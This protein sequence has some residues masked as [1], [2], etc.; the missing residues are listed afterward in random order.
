MSLTHPYVSSAQVINVLFLIVGSAFSA[1]TTKAQFCWS[2][3]GS[4]NGCVPTF[5][6]LGRIITGFGT[7]S[8]RLFQTQS[9]TSLNRVPLV[10]LVASGRASRFVGSRDC[11]PVSYR[12]T[13][14]CDCLTYSAWPQRS[15]SISP[16]H[17]CLHCCGYSGLLG[18]WRGALVLF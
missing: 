17:C 15:R 8:T 1:L 18:W 11:C 14:I 4:M 2:G 10:H 13:S 3:M 5:L 7:Q 6:F 16:H 12:V 9:L